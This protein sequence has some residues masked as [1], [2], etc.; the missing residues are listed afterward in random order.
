MQTIHPNASSSST[1]PTPWLKNEDDLL[2]GRRR[3]DGQ[4]EKERRDLIRVSNAYET[5]TLRSLFIGIR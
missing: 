1:P 4:R 3:G 2:L 5:I